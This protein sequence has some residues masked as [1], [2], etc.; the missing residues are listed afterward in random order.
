MIITSKTRRKSPHGKTCVMRHTQTDERRVCDERYA[1]SRSGRN[2]WSDPEP[3][4]GV[5]DRDF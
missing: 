5:P 3:I 1:D 4:K 2:G